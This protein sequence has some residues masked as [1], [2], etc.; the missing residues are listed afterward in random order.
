MLKTL[1]PIPF[2]VGPARTAF[3]QKL[4]QLHGFTVE[5]AALLIQR[6][7]AQARDTPLPGECCEAMTRRGEPCQAPAGVNGRCK[8][9]GGKSTGARTPEG[10]RKVYGWECAQ[11]QV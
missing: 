5:S 10:R 3:T 8:L 7:N 6:M 11:E 9:H 1:R 2:P 4:V